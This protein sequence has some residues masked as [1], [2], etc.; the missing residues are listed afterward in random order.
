MSKSALQTGGGSSK[1]LRCPERPLIL[2][3]MSKSQRLPVI[4]LLLLILSTPRPALAQADEGWKFSVYPIMGWLPIYGA[5]FDVPDTPDGGGGGGGGGGTDGAVTTDTSIDGALFF[6]FAVEKDRLRVD[7]FGLWAALGLDRPDRPV[8]DVDLDLIYG[9]LIGGFEI[10]PDV[11]ATGGAQR[12]ALEYSINV[13][14]FPTFNR[15]PG[16]WNPMVGVAWHPEMGRWALHAAGQYGGFG[17][18]FE[19]EFL[20]T[21]YADWKPI[22][23]FGIALGYSLWY[24]ELEDTR[25]F[26]VGGTT[27]SRTFRAEQT[28]HG[29]IA[30]IGFFF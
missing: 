12:V 1:L 5:E 15:K 13:E 27:V 6:G 9:T 14:D 29:P 4:L 19:N 2:V 18:G 28:L 17:A 8:L 21:F 16:V 23:N 26:I 3:A 11:Y 22:R 20:G 7:A 24:F 30:G 25:E 10:I